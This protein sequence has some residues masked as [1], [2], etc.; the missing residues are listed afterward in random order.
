[1]QIIPIVVTLELS[2]VVT[3]DSEKSCM[4]LSMSD[5]VKNHCKQDTTQA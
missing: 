2:A 3:F 4:S 5:C 1:M